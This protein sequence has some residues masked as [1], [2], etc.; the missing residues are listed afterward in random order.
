M[1]PTEGNGTDLLYLTPDGTVAIGKYGRPYPHGNMLLAYSPEFGVVDFYKPERRMMQFRGLDPDGTVW[2]SYGGVGP[3]PPGGFKWK[4][5]GP[6]I[7]VTGD[8]MPPYVAFD[9]V[10]TPI[11]DRWPPTL[12]FASPNRQW[13]VGSVRVP[14]TSISEYYLWSSDGSYTRLPDEFAPKHVHDSGNLLV[15]VAPP[16]Q[17]YAKRPWAVWLRGR[18]LIQIDDALVQAGAKPDEVPGF[19]FEVAGASP[20]R[21]LYICSLDRGFTKQHFLLR[22]GV[23]EP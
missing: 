13:A 12:S 6:E 15:G 23:P 3:Y 20:D 14:E 10:P 8:E 9:G 5:P 1:V 7:P 4:H 2:I 19:F 22:V 11:P 18:G 16:V 17:G 21:T